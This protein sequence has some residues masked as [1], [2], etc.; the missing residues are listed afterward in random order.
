MLL[1]KA[2]EEV[3]E[4]REVEL[5]HAILAL[6]RVDVRGLRLGKDNSNHRI[7]DIELTL[8]RKSD[9]LLQDDIVLPLVGEV[10]EGKLEHFIVG[11]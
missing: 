3:D 8:T 7:G 9:T 6:K 1:D 2:T 5:A 10:V 11:V 4:L